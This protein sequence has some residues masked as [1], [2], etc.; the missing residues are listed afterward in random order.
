[1]TFNGSLTLNLTRLIEIGRTIYKLDGLPQLV[2]RT[3]DGAAVEENVFRQERGT[4]AS[5]SREMDW[6]LNKLK[7]QCI[8]LLLQPVARIQRVPAVRPP[9][10]HEI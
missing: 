3:Q 8:S 5:S 2:I 4:T 10:Q 9:P 6:Q 1:M 7:D